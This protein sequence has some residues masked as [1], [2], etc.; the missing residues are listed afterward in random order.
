M[1][2]CAIR[3]SPIHGVSRLLLTWWPG[4]E[5]T[6]YRFYLAVLRGGHGTCDVFTA[7]GVDVHDLGRSKVD[8]RTIT[9][10]TKLIKKLDID[11][12][13]LHGY[14]ATTFGRI[15]GKLAGC[16]VIV[17]EHMVDEGIPFY[18]R[19]VD[20]LLSPLT[21]KGLAISN[22]VKAF[23][24][25]KRGISASKMQ[26]LYNTIPEKYFV[27]VTSEEKERTRKK[28]ALSASKRYVGIV[29]RLDLIK[30]QNYFLDAVLALRDRFDDVEY[31]LIG[32]GEL[33]PQLEG[34][35]KENQ[36]GDCVRFL[37]HCEDVLPLISLLDIFVSASISEGFG[38]AH[39]EA[40][41]Q[42][43]PI[44]A[45]AVGG[46]PELITENVSGLLVPPH[47]PTSMAGAIATLLDD[48]KKAQML[49]NNAYQSCKQDF[50]TP[51]TVKELSD[52][53]RQLLS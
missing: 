5:N 31:L 21:D 43:K 32:D 11:I 47:D 14:G 10:I 13:H 4:F 18:Q 22:A 24:I 7:I 3:G 19:M 45:T 38:M 52:V 36:L 48:G 15:A 2:K 23:M 42:R 25:D 17:H 39:A 6:D 27:E 12:L 37:G 35:V 16:K 26:V 33:R 28:Y 9:S 8:P 44:V 29:G 30:G 53:Y 51:R 40:M 50:T 1:D 41:A 34:F 46:V 20:K 49:A